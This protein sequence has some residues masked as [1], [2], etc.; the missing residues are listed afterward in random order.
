M[1]PR[2]RFIAALERRPLHGR[3]PHF[4]LVHQS[5]QGLV[6][7]NGPDPPVLVS[8]TPPQA[9]PVGRPDPGLFDDALQR[10][11]GPV[12]VHPD[13]GIGRPGQGNVVPLQ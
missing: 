9:N 7:R 5:E 3:V 10:H 12:D 4:E 1:K 8:E 13:S 2:D 11:R 6:R